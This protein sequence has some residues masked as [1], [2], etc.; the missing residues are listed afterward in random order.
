MDN[1][2]DKESNP[3]HRAVIHKPCRLCRY[4]GMIHDVIIGEPLNKSV[5]G[6][7]RKSLLN[8]DPRPKRPFCSSDCQ[9]NY[10]LVIL[11]AGL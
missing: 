4:L 10:D 7:C 5:C 1:S 2:V 3:K 6:W 11:D 8:V 9:W